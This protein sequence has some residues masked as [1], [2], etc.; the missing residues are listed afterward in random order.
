LGKQLKRLSMR[1]ICRNGIFYVEYRRGKKKSLKTRDPQLA[2]RIFKSLKR[3][4]LAGKL[5]ELT[6]K[7]PVI[8]KFA[9]QYLQSRQNT[10]SEN[11][12]RIDSDAFKKLLEY[13]G[14]IPLNHL[15]AYKCEQF[16]EHLLKKGFNPTTVNI[17]IRA[18]KAAFNKAVKWDI[19]DKSPFRNVQQ[20]PVKN[21]LPRALT[22]SE[23]KALLQVIK[24]QEFKEY[25]YTCLY[26]G[27]RRTEVAKLR[28]EDIKNLDQ[29]TW[30]I[31]F[32]KTKDEN[33]VI[34]MA[35]NLKKILFYRKKDIGP[36]F[37][38]YYRD[39]KQA[40]RDFRK[41]A[42]MAGI[43]NKL[44]DLRHTCATFMVLNKVPLRKIQEILGHTTI[45][46]T[47]IY[48]KLVAEDLKDDI[49]TLYW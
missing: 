13:T 26:T 49:N 45:K 33:K 39:P 25:V 38:R 21:A 42:D 34:P 19:I 27:A 47:E 6:G 23:V 40:S 11:T 20:I 5:I 44:H 24:D 15:S 41:Y 46:T 3:E 36:V 1:L 43:K 22:L 31:T 16:I 8:S 37:P 2:K 30:V 9:D 48:T 4:Y 7:A 14:D 35:E 32:R 18:L 28:W 12:L 10:R 29:T 17:I